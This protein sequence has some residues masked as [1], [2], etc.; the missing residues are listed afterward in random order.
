MSG[1]AGEQGSVGENGR[2]RA[3]PS[4]AAILALVLA[5]FSGVQTLASW[6]GGQA[7]IDRSGRVLRPGE[8][9]TITWTPLPRAVDE[10]EILLCFEAPV[11]RTL[12]LTESMDTSR[13]S[14]SWRVPNLPCACARIRIRAGSEEQGEFTWAWSPPFRIEWEVFGPAQKVRFREGEWWVSDDPPEDVS[15]VLEGS[16]PA[17]FSGLPA[18]ADC[19]EVNP[20]SR[21]GLTPAAV[22]G[23]SESVRPLP[24]WAYRV[25]AIQPRPPAVKLRI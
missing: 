24:A 18:S 23:R 10:F 7:A 15:S 3:F 14:Y 12:R 22:H 21:I 5:F 2:R 4:G 16:E 11:P 25:G 8:T 6:S 9:V 17:R 19:A 1:A 13:A 20:D